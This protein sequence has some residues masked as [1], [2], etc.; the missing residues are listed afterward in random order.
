[1]RRFDCYPV[2]AILCDPRKTFLE[3]PWSQ[4]KVTLKPT[5]PSFQPIVLTVAEEGALQVIAEF[6][7]VVGRA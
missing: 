6:V 7:E 3:I 5:N 1:M 2:E 4:V